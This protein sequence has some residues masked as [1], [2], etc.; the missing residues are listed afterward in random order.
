MVGPQ[1]LILILIDMND[2]ESWGFDLRAA[3]EVLATAITRARL[4]QSRERRAKRRIGVLEEK[5]VRSSC[6]LK[7][8]IM[9][10]SLA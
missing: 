9:P 10:K 7:Q 2:R 4:Q 8:N 6:D 1:Q 5:S 3:E